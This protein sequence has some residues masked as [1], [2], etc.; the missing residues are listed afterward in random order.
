MASAVRLIEPRRVRANPDNPRLIFHQSELDSLEESIK[1]QGILVPLTIYQ[2]GQ[3]YTLLDGERRWRCAL[4]LGLGKIPVII[5]DKPDKLTNIMMMF[6]IHNA[7]KDW[8]P[9]PTA[10]KLEQLERQLEKAIGKKPTEGELAGAASLTRG[11][12]RRYRK[13]LGLPSDLKKEL[14][15]ELKKPRTDQKL[16]VD[17]VLETISGTTQL[18]KREVITDDEFQPI[19]RAIVDKFRAGI[20]QNTTEPRK[21]SRIARS[22]ERGEISKRAVRT[23]LKALE[24]RPTYS[25]HNL[26]AE[27]VERL[28][29]EHATEQLTERLISRFKDL[30]SEGGIK[31]DAL[32]A[33]TERLQAL[34]RQL[35][36]AH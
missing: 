21:L 20:I 8:D 29:F 16:T 23:K 28:D 14:L 22:V 12:V 9:L 13:I 32:Y 27:T 36:H 4:R 17:H 34:L 11:E 5:Q 31:S 30:I 15:H 19:V 24:Q 35:L 6:A 10:L 25:I 1:H 18:L 33:S 2:D 26:F 7:R 3:R